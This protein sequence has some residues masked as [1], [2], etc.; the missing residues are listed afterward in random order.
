LLDLYKFLVFI[1]K[2]MILKCKFLF[3]SMG[4]YFFVFYLSASL[5]TVLHIKW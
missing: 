5:F 2:S 4:I 3:G 1:K